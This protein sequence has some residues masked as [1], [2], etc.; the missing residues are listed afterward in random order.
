MCKKLALMVTTY[1]VPVEVPMFSIMQFPQSTRTAVERANGHHAFNHSLGQ[2]L[3][4]VASAGGRWNLPT[5]TSLPGAQ[6]SSCSLDPWCQLQILRGRPTWFQ[7]SHGQLCVWNNEHLGEF[8][9]FSAVIG[10]FDCLMSASV[11]MHRKGR[12]V[13]SS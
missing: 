1:P 5:V 9:V 11:W 8:S 4:A 13:R 6:Q 2:P 7:E 3:H 12:R 10:V